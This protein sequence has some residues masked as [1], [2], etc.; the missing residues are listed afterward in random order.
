MAVKTV[1]ILLDG[2]EKS[3]CEPCMQQFLRTTEGI[4]MVD[5]DRRGT[6]LTITYD[7]AHLPLPRVQDVI[8]HAQSNVSEQ[9]QH[10][11]LVLTGLDCAD[12]A[13]TLERGVKRLTGVIHVNANFATS[14]MAV[15]YQTGTLSRTQIEQLIR[16]LGYDVV[17]GSTGRLAVLSPAKGVCGPSCAC[18]VEQHEHHHDSAHHD[19]VASPQTIQAVN[20]E[21]SFVWL[22]DFW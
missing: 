20:P 7:D 21:N 22:N 4:K 9:M 19:E 16:E 5:V 14:K 6:C 17:N 8:A 10:E 2:P 11:T 15:G 3:T 1:D 13:T 12:C 18:G